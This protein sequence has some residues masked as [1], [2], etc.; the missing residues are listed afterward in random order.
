MHD[1]AFHMHDQFH[2][3]QRLF[4]NPRKRIN[5]TNTLSRGPDGCPALSVISGNWVVSGLTGG[6][7]AAL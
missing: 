6:G 2:E 5:L 4:F 1:Q 3:F 7:A